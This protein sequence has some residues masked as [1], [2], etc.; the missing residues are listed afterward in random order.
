[1]W[2]RATILDAL[3][4]E[5][6]RSRRSREPVGVVFLDLDGFREIN[7]EHGQQVGDRVLAEVARRVRTAVRIS[8]GVGRI[9]GDEFLLVLPGCGAERTRF[10]ARRVLR[11]V[12]ARP[13]ELAVASLAVGV[14]VGIAAGGGGEEDAES[15]VRSAEEALLEVEEP[16]SG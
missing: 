13:V 7:E 14:K 4:R 1:V 11:A 8:D 10:T 12:T 15:M 5:L 16:V 3:E 9:G 2:T 6:A